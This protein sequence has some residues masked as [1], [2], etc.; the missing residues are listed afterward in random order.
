MNK[1]LQAFIESMLSS[2]E[3]ELNIARESH[4]VESSYVAHLTASIL[5][6]RIAGACMDV[7]GTL[8]E[9]P[10]DPKQSLSSK[11]LRS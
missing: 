1:P 11:L 4:H 7:N 3:Q 10:D 6:S 2:A 9:T 5:C 8:K